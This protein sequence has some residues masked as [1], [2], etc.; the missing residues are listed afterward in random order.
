[1]EKIGLVVEGGGMR[2]IFTA[3]VL[4]YF[5]HKGITFPYIAAVSG[6]AAAA[7]CYVARQPERQKKCL[8]DL[9]MKYRY[10]SLKNWMTKKNMIDYKLL[11]EDFSYDILPFDFDTFFKSETECEIVTS[12]LLTGE[13]NY[14]VEKESKKRLIDICHASSTIPVISQTVQVDGVPMLDGGICDPIPIHRAME[15][16]CTKNVVV[17]TRNPGRRSPYTNLPIPPFLYGKYPNIRQKM[18]TRGQ[19]YNEQMKFIEEKQKSGDILVIQPMKKLKVTAVERDTAKMMRLY[20][21]GW[22]CAKSI[23]AFLDKC[24]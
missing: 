1:M 18:K 6:G 24:K 8:I 3:G 12:N 16:G 10:I 14:F 23:H 4:D 13:A 21:E 9:Y 22:E 5:M 20:K 11:F 19:L 15:K 2:C 7:S 17:L